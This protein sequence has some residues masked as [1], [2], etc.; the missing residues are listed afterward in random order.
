MSHSY[1]NQLSEYVDNCNQFGKCEYVHMILI[2]EILIFVDIIL[3]NTVLLPVCSGGKK[4]LTTN[5]QDG[6]GEFLNF[7]FAIDTNMTTFRVNVRKSAVR[8]AT[9][10]RMSNCSVL[11]CTW[12]W[13]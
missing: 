3:G 10:V 13:S 1:N 5:C 8:K 9:R 11:V 6:L 12:F 7:K 4:H 2:T